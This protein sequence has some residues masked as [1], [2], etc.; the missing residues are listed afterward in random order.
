M[1]EGY[2][3]GTRKTLPDKQ[4]WQEMND[5]MTLVEITKKYHVST[6]TIYRHM[7]RLDPDIVFDRKVINPWTKD[8]DAALIAAHSSGETGRELWD[9]VPTRT[10]IA[11]K[12]RIPLLRSRRLI[13]HNRIKE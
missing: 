2:K 1:Y 3:L 11:V 13:G 10:H 7:R 12:A 9:S 8:E 6:G 4:I 5:G